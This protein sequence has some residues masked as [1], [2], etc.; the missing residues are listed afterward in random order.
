M[1]KSFSFCIFFV[2][3]LSV[4]SFSQVTKTGGIDFKQ[5]SLSN[6]FSLASTQRK[7]VF[8]EVF[9]NGCPHCEA[10]APVLAEKEVGDF[11]N[12]QFVSWKTEAN[13][14]ESK[15]LQKLKNVTYPEFPILFYFDSEGNLIHMAT[16]AE[17]HTRKEF[18]GEVIRHGKNAL[19]PQEQTSKYDAR[20]AAGERDLQFLVSYGKYAKAAKQETALKGI[21]GAFAMKLTTPQDRTSQV[22]FYVLQRFVNDF[23]SPLSK[24]FFSHLAEYKSKYP[25]KEVKEAGESI[26]FHSLFGLDADSYKPAEIAAMREQMVHIGVPASEAASRT[27]L[28]ELDAYMRLKDTKGALGVFNTYRKTSTTL[29]VADYA[30]MLKYFNEK[31]TDNA[32]L[33]EMPVWAEAGLSIAQPQERQSKI[34]ADLWY[35]LAE[36]Y[37]KAGQKEMAKETALKALQTA[38]VAKAELTRYEAQVERVK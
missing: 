34:V 5:G 26:I 8:I 12:G 6:L 9:L 3:C 33:S 27:M 30:Y 4:A 18:I 31:A 16:P 15:A 22:G 2:L 7:P 23:N 32:Y 38:K 24:Y 35:E 14:A 1:S 36:V 21:N 28:K 11:Y 20:F 17:M 19:N 29:S 25:E 10:L 37:S 13:S